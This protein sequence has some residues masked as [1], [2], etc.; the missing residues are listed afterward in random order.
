MM[1]RARIQPPSWAI[2]EVLAACSPLAR[3]LYRDLHAIA[4]K[5]GRL[6][7]RP[8]RIGVSCLPY[9]RC[10]VDALLEE[11]AA[12]G[13]IRR[14]AVAGQKFIEIPDFLKHQHPHIREAASDIPPPLDEHQPQHDQGEAEPDLDRDKAPPGSPVP[15]SV[16]RSG[17]GEDPG[18]VSV[19]DQPPRLA[20]D[21]ADFKVY[22]AIASESLRLALLDADESNATVSA[23]FSDL[24][25]RQGQRYDA[26]IRQRAIDA[27][28]RAREK[29]ARAFT[30]FAARRQCAD[31]ASTRAEG[32]A[33]TDFQP[34]ADIPVTPASA[35][36]PW[37]H[38][39]QPP[40]H[41]EAAA[42]VKERRAAKAA[43]PRGS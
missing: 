22:A 36:D 24:C 26:G 33:D 4:D 43:T 8:K 1:A 20:A 12:S 34:L 40:G 19:R 35:P 38:L 3:L 21:F 7:D 6:E 16:Y 31:A 42:A 23:I 10:D 2:D 41:S 29:H 11:L 9:D 37:G 17:E 15:V 14:Y 39:R 30:E 32:P 25:A 27:A 28:R 18:S 13:R 5:T